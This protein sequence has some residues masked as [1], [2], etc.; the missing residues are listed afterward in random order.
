V[1][2]P[3]LR[4]STPRFATG[5][6]YISEPA[7]TMTAAVPLSNALRCGAADWVTCRM[8]ASRITPLS[9]GMR[10]VLRDTFDLKK[11]YRVEAVE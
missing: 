7:A 8:P 5:A 10:R 3:T 2:S 1:L 4:C 9:D 11:S 6:S